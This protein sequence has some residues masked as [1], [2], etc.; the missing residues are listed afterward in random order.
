MKKMDT[1]S[2][3]TFH[4]DERNV[5]ND[6]Y[7]EIWWTEAKEAPEGDYWKDSDFIVVFYDGDG[8]E[9]PIGVLLEADIKDITM[10]M[11]KEIWTLQELPVRFNY[12]DYRNLTLPQLINLII[13][14]IDSQEKASEIAGSNLSALYTLIYQ[15]KQFPF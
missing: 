10:E 15:K 1:S 6:W 8:E 2:L 7:L 14:D 9:K 4:I 3:S 11:W 12:K 5:R 13:K